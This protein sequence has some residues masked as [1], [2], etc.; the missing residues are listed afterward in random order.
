[1]FRL[2]TRPQKCAA[3]F[4]R[5]FFA[6]VIARRAM[7]RVRARAGASAQSMIAAEIMD[8]AGLPT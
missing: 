8:K 6:C 4:L 3:G 7:A 5:A 2:K 1:L